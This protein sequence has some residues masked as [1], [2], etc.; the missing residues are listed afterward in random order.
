MGALRP[1]RPQREIDHLESLRLR[2]GIAV[3]QIPSSVQGILATTNHIKEFAMLSLVRN[4]WNDEH[5]VIISAEL[6]LVMTITVI[7]M[8]VGLSEVAHAVVAELNDV[9]DAIGS[10]NQSFGF[11]GFHG[12]KTAGFGG[13]FGGFG[14]GFCGGF[15]GGGGFVKA[16][17]PGSAFLDIVDVCDNNQCMIACDFPTPE[18]VPV[19]HGGW[20]W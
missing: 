19:V 18:A 14:G 9:G 10:L 6:V 11:S 16:W 5:G 15:G 2:G 8:T 17:T 4:F 12:L 13:G 7:G 1:E 3:W 20:W